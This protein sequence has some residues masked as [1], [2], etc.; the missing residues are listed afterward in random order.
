MAVIVTLKETKTFTV[1][2]G[3][4]TPGIDF[5]LAPGGTISGVVRETGSEN[6]LSGFNVELLFRDGILYVSGTHIDGS[7]QFKDVPFDTNLYVFAWHWPDGGQHSL[8]FWNNGDIR[9]L[10]VLFV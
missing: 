6:P 5:A 10:K 1:Q 2:A 9:I 7:Y 8:E 4:V 3:Q